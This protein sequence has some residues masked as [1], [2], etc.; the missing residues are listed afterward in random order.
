MD[1]MVSSSS[2]MSILLLSLLLIGVFRRIVSDVV[3]GVR[4][5]GDFDA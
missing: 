4:C 5:T 2:M 3:E 1:S